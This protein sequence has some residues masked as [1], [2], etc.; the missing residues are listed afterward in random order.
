VV[1]KNSIV[2]LTLNSGTFSNGSKSVRVAAVHGVA[3]F[4]G[5]IINKAG[6]YTL[7]ASDGVSTPVTSG[8]ISVTAAAPSQ[9]IFQ[10][11]PTT[12]GTAGVVLPTTKVALED[13]FGNIATGNTST[14]TLSIAMGPAG[15]APGS[16]IRLAAVRGI[17][18][19]SNLILRT[20][21]SYAFK[22][23][24]GSFTA[25][26][27]GTITVK[28]AAPS[29]LVVQQAPTIGTA[30]VALAPAIKVAIV[31]QFG[32]LVSSYPMVT[33]TLSSGKFSNGNTTAKAVVSG[34]IAMFNS[35][36]FNTAR[37]YRLITSDGSLPVVS[38]G[39]TINPAA[40]SKL[41]FQQ[42]TPASG[43]VGVTLS[44]AIKV[45]VQDT[46]YG[47]VIPV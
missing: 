16:T 26:K 15:F 18:T 34:G 8:I 38:F 13:A 22:A 47:A 17:A 2:T 45:A 30:G 14:V 10:S 7:T 31:D 23:T 33:F 39:M 35:L 36:I 11:I 29:H 32:N 5:L 27:S 12:V 21:G 3:T 1:A 19:F 43:T 40:A 9:M 6:R 20:S 37:S 42:A 46:V 25:P 44:P 28:A 41:V 24:S 4:T